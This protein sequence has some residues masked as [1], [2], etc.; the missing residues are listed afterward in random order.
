MISIVK[1]LGAVIC[2]GLNIELLK[3]VLKAEKPKLDYNSKSI[4]SHQLI[5]PKLRK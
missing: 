4:P 2:D 3:K 1:S 5:D